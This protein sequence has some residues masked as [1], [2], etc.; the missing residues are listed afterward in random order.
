MGGPRAGYSGASGLLRISYDYSGANQM[1]YRVEFWS[2]AG[3]LLGIVNKEAKIEFIRMQNCGCG[4]FDITLARQFNNYSDIIAY[5]NEVRVYV[6]NILYYSGL[7]LDITPDL[8]LQ[9][10]VRI[11][12]NGFIEYLQRALVGTQT[13][14]KNYSSTLGTSAMIDLINNYV[15]ASPY[16]HSNISIGPVES[17]SYSTSVAGIS[18]SDTRVADC[19]N[20]LIALTQQKTYGINEAKQFF[21]TTAYASNYYFQLGGAGSVVEEYRVLQSTGNLYNHLRV[22]GG[23]VAGVLQVFDDS[24]SDDLTS[25]SIYGRRDTV[26][27]VSS[28]TNID[29]AH[30]YMT[31]KL[32]SYAYPTKH[33]SIVLRNF[34]NGVIREGGL[35][36]IIMPDGSINQHFIVSATYTIDDGG[37][38][39]SIE[40]DN[41]MPTWTTDWKKI[42]MTL[43]NVQSQ[44]S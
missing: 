25:Q 26:D 17:A 36:N 3:N 42:Q 5:E 9:E 19:I 40:G 22:N 30:T 33:A 44:F 34:L 43:S 15:I 32:A 7:I 18:F 14:P 10:G 12:G 28:L 6:N 11:T 16:S 37:L 8:A 38:R 41:L 35:I 39:I 23:S 1:D 27:N 24:Y 21:V 13:S 20:T 31:S 4:T 2:P 29:D